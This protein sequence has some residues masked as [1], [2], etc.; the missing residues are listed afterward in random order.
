MPGDPPQRSGGGERERPRRCRV[1]GEVQGLVEPQA[2]RRD[3]AKQE[4]APKAGHQAERGR[5]VLLQCPLES[6]LQVLELL[7]ELLDAA[8]LVVAGEAPSGVVREMVEILKV[9]LTGLR[10]V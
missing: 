8:G 3:V 2:P 4:E 1:G 7:D 10:G 5:I 9:T 6:H